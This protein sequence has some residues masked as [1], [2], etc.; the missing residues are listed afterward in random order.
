MSIATCEFSSV[1][2]LIGQIE[3]GSSAGICAICGLQTEH[4]HAKA[5][6]DSF[7]AWASVFGGDLVCEYCITMLRTKAYR[8][9]SWIAT[10]QSV[11]FLKS[12]GKRQQLRDWLRAPPLG[13]F[14]IYLT[15]NGQ[16]QGWLRL[17]RYV[18]NSPERF[19]IG[20]DWRDAP[21]FV[22][23]GKILCWLEDAARLRERGASRGALLGEPLSSAI[24]LKAIKAGWLDELMAVRERASAP[25]WEIAVYVAE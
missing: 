21:L 14:A 20:C 19:W 4:G 15:Q 10:P 7:T 17:M 25:E 11:L 9:Q 24:V 1:S 12:T 18:S 23:R 13:P 2:R 22:E 3:L 8:M 5:F 16:K 6:S